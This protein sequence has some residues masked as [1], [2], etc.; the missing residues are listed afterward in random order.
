MINWSHY[1]AV[2]PNQFWV[3]LHF[4]ISKIMMAP[5]IFNSYIFKILL[6]FTWKKLRRPLTWS[7]NKP[8]QNI[9]IPHQ[10]VTM[11]LT[12]R[13]TELDSSRNFTLIARAS[14]IRQSEVDQKCGFQGHAHRA[15]PSI[16]WAW[17]LTFQC[18]LSHSQPC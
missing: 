14:M 13:I 7:W 9:A 4:G 10:N 8:Y 16:K 2:V 11:H 1:R 17:H 5:L 12:L 18:G 6:Q 15:K 3:M